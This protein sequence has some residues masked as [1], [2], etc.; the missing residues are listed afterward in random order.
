MAEETSHILWVDMVDSVF[1]CSKH[2]LDHYLKLISDY[3]SITTTVVGRHNAQ[4][5]SSCGDGLAISHE[6]KTGQE[7]I[8]IFFE[9]KARLEEDL[10]ITVTGGM[11]YGPFRLTRMK[12]I[13]AQH[14]TPL[15]VGNVVDAYRIEKLCAKLHSSLLL[16]TSSFKQIQDINV[17]G[18]FEYFKKE[19]KVKSTLFNAV[20]KYTGAH[21][22]Y[23]KHYTIDT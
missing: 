11:N 16:T 19:M 20:Y 13:H 1:L 9:I 22:G 14:L 17:S 18:Q 12:I 5:L 8:A 10:N 23:N 21:N 7:L 2:G 6:D 15:L 3:Y 4:I